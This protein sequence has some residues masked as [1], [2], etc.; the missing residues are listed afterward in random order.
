MGR[1][2]ALEEAVS[3]GD[4]NDYYPEQRADEGF[5]Y[6]QINEP[7]GARFALAI[8]TTADWMPERAASL[9][10]LRNELGHRPQ[11]YREFR[12][13]A[14][15]WV[16]SRE[17]WRWAAAMAKEGATHLVQ[18]QDDVRPMPGFW[19]VLRA[20]VEANPER[21]I[22]LHV[23][24]PVARNLAHVGRRW[25]RT[26]AW[27]VG[28]QYVVP[29]R[30]PDSIQAFLAWLETT[31]PSLTPH[32]SEHED[33]TLSTW[34]ASTGRDCWHP[35]PAI[36]DVDLSIGSTYEGVEGHIDDHRRPCVTWHGY[37]PAQ[38]ATREYWQVPAGTELF[39]GPDLG[40]CTVC[41]KEPGWIPMGK[42]V[43]LGRLC[44]TKAHGKLAGFDL[45]LGEVGN[46]VR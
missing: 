16:W 17:L 10:R 19:G 40:A 12:E 29:L 24:H 42:F 9:A 23:N 27:L 39:P 14:P 36:A 43:T 32:Q 3:E 30:G 11:W 15:N 2:L 33:V 34:L 4:W 45:M 18:L 26:R 21:V 20:M 7:A 5:A 31:E 28:P 8:P 38:L 25:F 44:W 22:G 1:R 41:G 35:I 37:N 46:A 13:R 6:P